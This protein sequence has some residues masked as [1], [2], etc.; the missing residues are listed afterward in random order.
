[1]PYRN[2]QGNC[3]DLYNKNLI[4]PFAS[5]SVKIENIILQKLLY[6]WLGVKLLYSCCV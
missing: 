6:N 4:Y 1:M 2:Q 3:Q 5:K